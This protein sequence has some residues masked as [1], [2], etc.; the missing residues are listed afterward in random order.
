VEL[1]HIFR[2]LLRESQRKEGIY[3]SIRLRP[4]TPAD[5]E[6]IAA[7]ITAQSA[8]PTSAE[9]IAWQDQNRPAST[10]FL[11]LVAVDE[12]DQVLG[13]TV[14]THAE[15]MA[16]G[17]FLVRVR[18]AA[19]YQGKGAGRLLW[20]AMLDWVRE[21]GCTSMVS[22][23]LEQ[24]ARSYAIAQAEGFVQN[25]HLFE[26]S[27][28]L[29]DWDPTPWQA[30]VVRAEASGIRFT[31]LPALG[32]SEMWLKHLWE[33]D[34]RLGRDVPSNEHRGT[35]SYETWRQLALENPHFTPEGVHLAM[36]GDQI[37]GIAI[38][39]KL[40]SGGLYNGFTG[41]ERAY[42][43][44]GLALALKVKAL[45]W[46]RATGAPYIRTNNH[47]VNKPMLAV[48]QKLGYKPEPGYFLLEKRL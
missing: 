8:E 42:R 25:Y 23:V 32:L 5:F 15:G 18:V 9:T 7:I 24:D 34:T 14:G 29:P 36:D 4:A 44:R 22:S 1:V 30:S 43:G 2:R 13:Y 48:N 20:S 45:Q 33:V 10:L 12:A 19:S 26:S 16:P 41:V 6:A 28:A 21:N 37:V 27:L 47:S 11:R 38:V 40:D 3:L 39:S 46:A 31:T 35:L 17:E